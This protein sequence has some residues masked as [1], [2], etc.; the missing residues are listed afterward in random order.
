SGWFAFILIVSSFTIDLT[1]ALA[2][3]SMETKT[4][5]EENGE[6]EGSVDENSQETEPI[7]SEELEEA[8]DEI[9]EDEHDS[10]ESGDGQEE[11]VEDK[12]D[13]SLK[14]NTTKNKPNK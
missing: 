14:V 1:P 4:N 12:E 8:V 7:N 6:M 10:I 11:V 2:S 3:E 9:K 13:K 5:T